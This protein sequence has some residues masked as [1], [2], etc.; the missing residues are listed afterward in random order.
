MTHA[1]PPMT[2]SVEINPQVVAELR[3]DA[4]RS[5]R[6]IAEATGVTRSSVQTTRRRLVAANEIADIKPATRAAINAFLH[7]N[8]KRGAD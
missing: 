2:D 4:R 1:C 6:M 5:D 8:P 3:R 7:H